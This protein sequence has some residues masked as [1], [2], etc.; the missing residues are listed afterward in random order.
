MPQQSFWAER[1]QKN[2]IGFHAAQTNAFL[3]K[4]M[5]SL[6]PD[7]TKKVLV[8]LCG[9]TLDLLFLAEHFGEVWGVEYIEQ[10]AQDFFH[11][12]NIK[13]E[14]EETS[15]GKLYRAGRIHFA[16]ADIF[17]FLEKTDQ[18]FDALYDRAALIALEEP[19]RLTYA[20]G[21]QKVL[22][23][24]A[25]MLLIT[26][27]Y[28]QEDMAGPPFSVSDEETKRLFGAYAELQIMERLDIL[29]SETKWRERGATRMDETI[30]AG[31][32]RG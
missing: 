22:T 27:A 13:A 19:R 24:E 17:L 4:Y 16:V 5:E 3:Q 11:E 8:P 20:Q 1:W 26:L 25:A 29:K 32:V 30:F 7:P 21:L 12:Q 15:Y 23:Q 6:K 9:K 28:P 18:Q 31:M 10:A 2:E 14:I